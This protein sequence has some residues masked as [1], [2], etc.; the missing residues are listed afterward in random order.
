[1]EKKDA[2][3]YKEFDSSSDTSSVASDESLEQVAGPN[4]ADFARQ[5]TF[6]NGNEGNSYFTPFEQEKKEVNHV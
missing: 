4:F 5:L 2:P 6:K 3:K 1:M